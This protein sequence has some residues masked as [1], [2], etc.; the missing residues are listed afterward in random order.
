MSASSGSAAASMMSNSA[1]D[2]GTNS[3]RSSPPTSVSSGSESWAKPR[4]SRETK[5][6]AWTTYSSLQVC[7][8]G[9]EAPT[10]SDPVPT[11]RPLE[12]Q[13]EGRS[14]EHTSELQSLMRTSYADFCLK[15]NT[16][17]CHDKYNIN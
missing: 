2:C 14:E 4:T 6:R 8:S 10:M 5:E 3:H 11:V 9:S 12:G 15:K 7:A 17:R 13:Q 16:H 1:F